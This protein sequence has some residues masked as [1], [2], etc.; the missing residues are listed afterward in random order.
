MDFAGFQSEG[1]AV[2]HL[3]LDDRRHSLDDVVAETRGS[4]RREE[5]AVAENEPDIDVL[6]ADPLAAA[7]E[8]VAFVATA[9]QEIR[10]IPKISTRVEDFQECHP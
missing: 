2:A 1:D 10:T 9:I 8:P 3:P 6:A 7:E 4:E 5:E